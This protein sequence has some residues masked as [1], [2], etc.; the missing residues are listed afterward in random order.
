MLCHATLLCLKFQER[1]ERNVSLRP[2]TAT[3]RHRAQ[4]PLL[5]ELSD[6]CVRLPEHHAKLTALPWQQLKTGTAVCPPMVAHHRNVP[7]VPVQLHA[8]CII[9]I[10]E[11]LQLFTCEVGAVPKQNLERP[12]VPGQGDI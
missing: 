8:V 11:R 9:H 1:I 6:A 10:H 7:L 4:L 12:C 5:L 2:V 3:V